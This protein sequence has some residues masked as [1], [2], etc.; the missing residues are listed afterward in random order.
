MIAADLF[1]LTVFQKRKVSSIPCSVEGCVSPKLSLGLCSAHYGRFRQHGSTDI[2]RVILDV[3]AGYKTAFLTVTGEIGKN[4]LGQRAFAA[5]CVCGKTTFVHASRLL[6]GRSKS[7]GCKYWGVG[8]G[9]QKTHGMAGTPEWKAWAHMRERCLNPKAHEYRNYGARGISICER[10]ESFKNFYED[11][12]TRPSAGHSID[13][14][15]NN[16][17]DYEPSNCRW[18]TRL[19]QQ[20]NRRVTVRVE[21]QGV[22]RSLA[23]LSDEVGI[24]YRLAACR[25]KNGWDVHRALTEPKQIGRWK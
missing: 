6:S 10:W 17:G 8:K 7:C 5:L 16:D 24:P 19:Q 2:N 23:D 14:F 12:G 9:D 20:R 22:V 21:Y 3:P 4:A 15:P 13:R 25:V 18:A 11:M 1:G